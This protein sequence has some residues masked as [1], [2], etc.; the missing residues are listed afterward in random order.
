MKTTNDFYEDLTNSQIQTQQA[1]LKYVAA[2]KKEYCHECGR[3]MVRSPVQLH[4]TGGFDGCYFK[5]GYEIVDK[6]HVICKNV[7][8]RGYPGNFFPSY[9]SFQPNLNRL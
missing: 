6:Q 5:L 1:Y 3:E 9:L 4:C 2:P 8:A 7:K